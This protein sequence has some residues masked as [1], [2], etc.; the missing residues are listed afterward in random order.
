MSNVI[1]W[2]KYGRAPARR[3]PEITLEIA[4]VRAERLQ[5]ISESDARAETAPLEEHHAR[6]CAWD[7]NPRV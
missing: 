5:Y 7:D 1:D 2:S 3:R 6:G 4:H